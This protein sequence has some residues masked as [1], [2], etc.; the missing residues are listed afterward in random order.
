MLAAEKEVQLEAGLQPVL[1][2]PREGQQWRGA[3]RMQM[4]AE[5]EP[6]CWAELGEARARGS[7]C[8]SVLEHMDKICH[9]M[10]K[11]M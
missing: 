4:L 6:E 9:A 1:P 11:E 10:G 3:D 8:K 2:A 7:M 5:E